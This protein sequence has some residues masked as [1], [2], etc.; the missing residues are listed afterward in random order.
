MRTEFKGKVVIAILATAFFGGCTPQPEAFSVKTPEELKQLIEVTN[1]VVLLARS[2]EQDSFAAEAA[3]RDAIAAVGVAGPQYRRHGDAITGKTN[4]DAIACARAQAVE[5]MD[6]EI[7]IARREE[8]SQRQDEA[9]SRRRRSMMRSMAMDAGRCAALNTEQLIDRETRREALK[10]G[11]VLISE[12]YAIAAIL[13][14]ANDLPLEPVLSDQIRAY[15][16]LV[17]KLG[18]KHDVQVVTDALPKLKATLAILEESRS[19]RLRPE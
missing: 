6:L 9:S 17:A 14:A 8:A 11:A 5:I 10:H 16:S 2:I 15:E 13:S 18:P 19:R 3:M 1:R 7:L 4:V 12:A